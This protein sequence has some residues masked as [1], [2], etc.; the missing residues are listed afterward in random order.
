[1]NQPMTSKTHGRRR[2]IIHDAAGLTRLCLRLLFYWRLPRIEVRIDALPGLVV[3]YAQ[4]RITQLTGARNTLL[5]EVFAIVVL[6]GGS[7]TAWWL[8]RGWQLLVW[9]AAIA[10]CGWLAGKLVNGTWTRLRLLALLL[11]LRIQLGIASRGKVGAIG[12]RALAAP[13]QYQGRRPWKLFWRSS[14][15]KRRRSETIA[16]SPQPVRPQKT[17]RPKVS[18]RQITDIDRLIV[19][20]ASR[21]KLPRVEIP[22]AAQPSLDVQRA[23]NL[24]VRLSEASHCMLGGLL[25]AAALVGASFYLI[26]IPDPTI[27][28]ARTLGWDSLAWVLAV[29]LGAAMIGA[30]IELIW[31]RM[32][33][34]L[35]LL[36]LR[37]R[38][39]SI[40]MRA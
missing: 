5:G 24:F 36:R 11:R 20:V 19:K 37:R 33:L 38:I 10:F 16:I 6:L 30:V 23:Q 9:V 3:Q 1:M 4:H 7:Y 35:V 34:V 21:W 25:G 18:L 26:W 22:V 8:A 31:T 27:T 29:A 13:R 32:R 15:A 14:K 39:G 28:W 17:A 12:R 40:A 2:V